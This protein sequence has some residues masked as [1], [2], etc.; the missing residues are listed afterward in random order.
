VQRILPPNLPRANEAMNSSTMF[1]NEVLG[2][3][4]YISPTL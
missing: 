4:S 1:I 3:Q 2:R